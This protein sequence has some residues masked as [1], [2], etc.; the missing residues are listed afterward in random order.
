MDGRLHLKLSK[1][2][3]KTTATCFKEIMFVA[4]HLSLRWRP[5][6]VGRAAIIRLD[7]LPI[8][9]P[10][11][12]LPTPLLSQPRCCVARSFHG[13]TSLLL[14]QLSSEAAA[15]A[16][17]GGDGEEGNVPLPFV[18][19]WAEL[20]AKLDENQA[21]QYK[22]PKIPDKLPRDDT[23]IAER[24]ERYAELTAAMSALGITINNK[25]RLCIDYIKGRTRGRLSAAEVAEVMAGYRYLNDYSF[26][27]EARMAK[28]QGKIDA[29]TQHLKR[30][31]GRYYKGIFADACEAGYKPGFKTFQD[32]RKDVCATWTDWPEVWPWLSSAENDEGE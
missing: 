17:S 19:R 30:A 32:I 2:L 24:D 11:R 14:R 25:S 3:V 13:Q 10:L 4:T 6:I 7:S 31:R 8:R 12:G 22:E 5:A 20:M 29:E 28:F 23:L 9:T 16:A 26:E 15:P 27:Y 21:L 1:P 18:A